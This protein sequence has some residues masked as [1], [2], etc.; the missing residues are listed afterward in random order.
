MMLFSFFAIPIAVHGNPVDKRGTAAVPNVG[1]L[2]D[3][4][5]TISTCQISFLSTNKPKIEDAQWSLDTYTSCS[6]RCS[7][8][9]MFGRDI[10][11]TTLLSIAGCNTNCGCQ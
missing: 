10:V 6:N 1:V 4:G 5:V 9:K 8:Y 3:R 7:F 2:N 11:A